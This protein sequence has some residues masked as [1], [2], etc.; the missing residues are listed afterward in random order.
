MAAVEDRARERGFDAV[1][2]HA[3]SHVESWYR[4][5]GY[6]TLGDPFEEAGIEHVAM[7]KRV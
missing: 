6:E 2:L 4:T 3:Q 7:R 5:Q 1:T